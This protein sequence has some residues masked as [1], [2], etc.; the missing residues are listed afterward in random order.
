[1]YQSA[2]S[3][4]ARPRG[5]VPE[6]FLVEARW[7]NGAEA[8][9]ANVGRVLS[10]PPVTRIASINVEPAD[11]VVRVGAQAA[12]RAGE[13]FGSVLVALQLPVKP[14]YC[15]RRNFAPVGLTKG[16]H[17]HHVHPPGIEEGTLGVVVPHGLKA[18]DGA[19]E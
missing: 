7:P 2:R 19:P 1:M 11:M 5:D 3:W 16:V 14:S 9:R 13:H 18:L 12:F 8:P 17:M 4:S 6:G 10:D 15:N